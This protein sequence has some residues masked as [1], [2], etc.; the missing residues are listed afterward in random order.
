MADAEVGCIRVVIVDD[1]PLVRTG[2][3]AV[4]L[5]IADVDLVGSADNGLEAV[6]LCER[7]NPDVVLMDLVM[8]GMNGVEA[9]AEIRSRCPNTQVLVLTSYGDDKLFENALC[10]GAIGILLKNILPADLATAIRAAHSGRPTVAPE[11]MQALVQ[12]VSG[13]PKPGHDLTARE[14]EILAMMVEGITN[15]QIAERLVLSPLTVKTHV[16]HIIRKLGVATRTEAATLAIRCQ[17]E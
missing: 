14:R 8:P 11:A 12:S 17:L 9:T 10:A 6:G 2:L 4:L 16:S 3:K 15:R 13:S 5:T 7:L 1:H